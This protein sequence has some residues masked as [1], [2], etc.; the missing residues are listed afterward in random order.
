MTFLQL[1]LEF[2]NSSLQMEDSIML[3]YA[4]KQEKNGNLNVL[5]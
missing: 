4:S 2:I 5:K 3:L 1:L